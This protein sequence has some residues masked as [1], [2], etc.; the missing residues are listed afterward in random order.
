[1]NEHQD[2][3][4]KKVEKTMSVID[5][6]PK[7]APKPFFYGRLKAR[8]NAQKS[9][10]LGIEMAMNLRVSAVVVVLL[11]VI[12]CFIAFT[13]EGEATSSDDDYSAILSDYNMESYTIY[14][15]NE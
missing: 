7:A 9:R 6:L 2:D 4:L 15:V 14:D 11:L 12:N 13:Y 1:M 5:N 3:H 10:F 8:M